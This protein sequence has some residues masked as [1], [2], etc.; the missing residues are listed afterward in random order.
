ML[1]AAG[2]MLFI[3]SSAASSA[4]RPAVPETPDVEASCPARTLL[5]SDL[6]GSAHTRNG[7]PLADLQT[8]QK[9]EAGWTP[10]FHRESSN[11]AV[12][13][14]VVHGATLLG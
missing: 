3:F 1:L 10:E 6:P 5:E 13:A 7:L 9:L 8:I 2:C 4:C 11:D 14:W 12:H